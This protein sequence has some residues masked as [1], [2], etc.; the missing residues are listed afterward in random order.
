MYRSTDTFELREARLYEA[1]ELVVE[2][3]GRLKTDLLPCE[4]CMYSTYV[5]NSPMLL[6][7]PRELNF[8]MAYDNHVMDMG[9]PDLDARTRAYAA[10]TPERIRDV[11]ATILTRDNLTFTMKGRKKTVDLH[12]VEQILAGL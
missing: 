9:Y 1:L 6:D 8:T 7:S 2:L 11:F 5:D 12:R 3:L 10:V 4:R